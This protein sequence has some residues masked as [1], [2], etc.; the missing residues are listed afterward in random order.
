MTLRVGLLGLGYFAQFHAEAWGRIEGASLV[1]TTDQNPD[2]GPDHKDINGLLA[3]A[4]D[5]VDIATPPNTHAAAVRAALDARPKAIICQKPFCTSLEEARAVAAEASLDNIPLIIH[6]NFRFQ[7]WFRTMRTAI[8]A[9]RLGALFQITFRL[10]P[11]DGQGPDAY[12]ARQ[13]YFQKMPRLLIHETGVHYLDTF[14]F[15]LGEPDG[16]YADLRRLNP[17]IRGEDAGF[18]V[19][20]YPSGARAILDGN[21]LAD[22]DTD[23][24]RRTFGDCI[25]EG[26][27]GAITLTGDGA[28]HLRAHGTQKM[29]TLLA[30]QDW[31]GFAGDCV[32]AFQSH[33]VDHLTRGTPLETLAQD[34]LRSME[35]VEIAY[36]SSEAGIRLPV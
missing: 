29:E 26:A 20:D 9:G 13:P 6:E 14:R 36:S 16:L 25:A 12:L 21:R 33:V 30:P 27:A 35:L 1:A 32:H 34:Y 17:V 10:R 3:E 5:I 19:L 23:T 2:A 31:P 22:F 8:E 7:P 28:L 18:V 24:P 15:L 11:G 4:L